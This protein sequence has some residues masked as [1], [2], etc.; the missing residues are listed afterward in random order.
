MNEDLIR[1]IRG[2]ELSE[3]SHREGYVVAQVDAFLDDICSALSRGDEVVPLIIGARFRASRRNGYEMG[4]VDQL[5]DL[6]VEGVEP[7]VD[8]ARTGH[9]SDPRVDHIRETRF[10]PVFR[11]GYKMGEVDAF[12]D[13]LVNV[14]Q[15]DQPVR[16]LVARADFSRVRL[17]EGYEQSEVHALL[18]EIDRRAAERGEAPARDPRPE[19]AVIQEN[20]GLLSRLF[21]RD[22]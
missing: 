17:G 11:G 9:P 10:T 12:L 19:P 15:R 5:L 21:G 2:T 14:L 6:I 16:G 8:R 7:G 22:E 1:T 4:E 20:K 13:D 3:V 18:A